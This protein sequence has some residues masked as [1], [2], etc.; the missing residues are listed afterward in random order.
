[1]RSGRDGPVIPDGVDVALAGLLVAA[2]GGPPKKSRP[3]KE[4]AGSGCFVGVAVLAGVDRTLGASVVLGLTGG[5]GISPNISGAGALVSVEVVC[6]L[7][8]VDAFCCEAERSSFAFS[9]TTLR[10]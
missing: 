9:W 6:R 8:E 3:N 7:E 5:D 1:M 2:E 4:F 10:G